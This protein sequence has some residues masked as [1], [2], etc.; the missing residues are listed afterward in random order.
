MNEIMVGELSE[1]AEGGYRVLRVDSFEFGIFREGDRL[2]RRETAGCDHRG[3]QEMLRRAPR[4]PGRL[5]QQREFSG[6]VEW[7]QIELGGDDH[8]HLIRPEDRIHLAMGVQ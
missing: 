5:I 6:E 4:I 2:S 1:F 8:N 7:V 3:G